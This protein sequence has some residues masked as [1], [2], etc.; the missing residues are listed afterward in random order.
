[1]TLEPDLRKVDLSS[2]LLGHL[3]ERRHEARMQPSSGVQVRPPPK[4]TKLRRFAKG[5]RLIGFDQFMNEHVV[6]EDIVSGQAFVNGLLANGQQFLVWI[7]P[8]DPIRRG[9][10]KRVIPRRGK[11]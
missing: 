6:T 2:F 5:V 7:Q 8:K 11:V 1:M 3:I 9:L 10:G 4:E